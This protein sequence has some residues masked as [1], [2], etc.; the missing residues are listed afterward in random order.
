M[1][2]YEDPYATG[3]DFSLAVVEYFKLNPATIGCVTVH[4]SLEEPLAVNIPI[5]LSAEDLSGIAKLMKA[6]EAKP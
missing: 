5:F 6:K 4:T 3:R 2:D 1:I